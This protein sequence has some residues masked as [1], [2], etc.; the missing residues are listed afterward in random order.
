MAGENTVLSVDHG[1]FE[2]CGAGREPKRCKYCGWPGS[3]LDACDVC[4]G[5][6][7]AL[8]RNHYWLARSSHAQPPPSIP[9]QA[10]SQ[11]ARV[12]LSTRSLASIMAW[13]SVFV[14]ENQSDVETFRCKHENKSE[15]LTGAVDSASSAF[16]PNVAAR[17][18]RTKQD[19]GVNDGFAG[20][21]GA[22]GALREVLA[23]TEQEVPQPQL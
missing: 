22:S 11:W 12:R 17:G 3:M 15:T 20:I 16:I 6:L 5:M 9:H 7:A 13:E 2:I 14:S 10:P 1:N 4:L 23:Q 18:L 8:A 19:K 21:V